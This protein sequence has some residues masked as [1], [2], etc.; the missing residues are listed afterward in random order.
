MSTVTHSFPTPMFDRL[1]ADGDARLPDEQALRASIARDLGRLLNTRSTCAHESVV[2]VRGTVLDY[3]VPDFSARSLHSGSDRVAIEAAVARAI[4]LF[5]PRLKDV[6]VKFT[7]MPERVRA[8]LLRVAARMRVGLQA[9]P[10][11]FEL[12]QESGGHD[13]RWAEPV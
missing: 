2:G 3:G 8:P 11:A 5:E 9:D 13:P 12:E 4:E 6:S 1:A 10:V 7:D